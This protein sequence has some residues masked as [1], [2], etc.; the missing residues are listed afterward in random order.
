MWEPLNGGA[1]YLR[2]AGNIALAFLP[3]AYIAFHM[4]FR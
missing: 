1:V 2:T 3:A 4:L